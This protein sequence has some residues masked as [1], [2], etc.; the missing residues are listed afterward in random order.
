MN[1]E[2]HNTQDLTN[3][4]ILVSPTNVLRRIFPSGAIDESKRQKFQ[5]QQVDH[6]LRTRT[7]K[8]KLTSKTK[9]YTTAMAIKAKIVKVLKLVCSQEPGCGCLKAG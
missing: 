7:G 6:S 4:S 1:H 2:E 8:E 3:S 9:K 5:K